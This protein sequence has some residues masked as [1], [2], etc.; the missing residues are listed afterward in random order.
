M[1]RSNR[2]I[3]GLLFLTF[4]LGLLGNSSLTT[5][6]PAAE[7]A[8]NKAE[9]RGTLRFRLFA[10]RPTLW[11]R[12]DSV[13]PDGSVA[14]SLHLPEGEA[15]NL[16]RTGFSR[17]MLSD[18]TE[19]YYLGLKG[20]PESGGMSLF[21][22]MS[23][24][25]IKIDDGRVLRVRITE[26]PVGG[27]ALATVGPG[28]LSQI[29]TG[30]RIVLIRPGGSSTAELQAVPDV[31]ALVDA[32]DEV[33]GMGR[34][35]AAH[36][37]R[38]KNNLKQIGIAIH[39]FHD[40]Y[41]QF[42]PAVV[43][44][45]DGK[46]WHSWRVL[47]LPYLEQ[48]VLYDRYRF[49]EPWDSPH[50]K[51]LLETVPPVFQDP[52]Y[53]K[54]EG[55]YTHYAA[56][57]GPGT[58]FPPEGHTVREFP[59]ERAW[60]G[61][62]APSGGMRFALIRDGSSNTVLAGSVSPNRKIPWT[63]PEDVAFGDSFPGI[64]REGGFAAPYQTEN[65]RGGVFLFGDG[66]VKAIRQDVDG[67][68]LRNLIT[69]AD[70]TPIGEVPQFAPTHPR[71]EQIPVV[72]IRRTETG[73]TAKLTLETLSPREKPATAPR[74]EPAT[75][76]G[77][78]YVEGTVTLHGEPLSNALV[79]FQ[80]EH[81]RPSYGRTDLEGWYELV[82]TAGNKGAKIGKHRVSISTKAEGDP[83]ADPP[84]PS[85]PEK[86]PAKYNRNTELTADVGDGD[87]VI[88]FP[89][90]SG[91][92][93]DD[94]TNK[95]VALPV[96]VRRA[97]VVAP[98]APVPQAPAARVIA[99]RPSARP[100]A[101]TTR[102][103]RRGTAAARPVAPAVTLPV[104]PAAEAPAP[105]NRET[106]VAQIKKLGG[107]LLVKGY[108]ASWSPDG[109]KIVFGGWSPGTRLE[110]GEGLGV[111]DLQSGKTTKLVA[112]GKD[113]AWS[114]GDGKWIAYVAGGYGAAEEVWVVEASGGEPRKLADG[115]YPSWLPDGKTVVF[116]SRKQ[117]KLMAV[118]ID[119]E[120]A[121]PKEL[122]NFSSWYPAVSADG[123]RVA[124]RSGS[125]QGRSSL[126]V[127]DLESGQV[128]KILPTPVGGRGFLG[129]WSP[130]GKRV[131]FG[132]FGA[133]DVAG[134]WTVN[135][136]NGQVVRISAGPC[137][138][139]AWSPDGSKIA[140]DLRAGESN[141]IWMVDT[142]A[143]DKLEPVD[144]KTIEKLVDRYAVPDGGPEVVLKYIQDLR[145][146]RPKTREQYDEH[147]AKSPAALA[148]AAK[149]I[150]KLEKDEWSEAYQTALLV[151]L[152]D[153]VR[154]IREDDLQRRRETLRHVETFLKAK[155]EKGLTSADARLAYSTARALEYADNPA[156][157][158]KAYERLAEYVAKVDDDRLADMAKA[159]EGAARRLSLPGNPMKLEGTMMDGAKFDWAAYRGKVV[160]VDFWATWCGPC[161]AELPNV[162]KNY[163]R[164]HD[165]GFDVI[166]VSLDR[167]REALEK[168]LADEQLPWITLH[169]KEA[170]GR[171]P[172]AAHYGIMAIPTVLLIDRE[173]NVASLRAR[174]AELDRLLGELIGPPYDP[175]GKLTYLDLQPQANQKLAEN[176][177]S[178]AAGG[179][180]LAELPAGEQ[181]FA[182]VK[183]RIGEG[184]IQLASR[185]LPDRPEKVDGIGVDQKLGR[186]YILHATGWGSAQD[187]VPDGTQIGEYRV[188]YEDGGEEA[189]PIVYG[190]DVRDW[191][192]S[193]G[194][195]SVTRGVLAWEGQNEAI[196][197]SAPDGSRSLRLYLL[198]WENP[199]PE[200]KI[201][202]IDY[203]STNETDAA[204]FCVAITA[205]AP[206]GSTEA[207]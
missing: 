73:A 63:K 101:I 169:E 147:R 174:G 134:L 49:N 172:I 140:F 7:P 86:V 85:F 62:S 180:N 190:Q 51:Q 44:G 8:S 65:A 24:S 186:L 64:G 136:E 93:I 98:A 109:G 102:S 175:K 165:R 75:E 2:A 31:V 187:A 198:A 42:P 104:A 58:A 121:E 135:V 41:K 50:N 77:L 45:P 144:R 88:D 204:P 91:S 133:H 124:Y 143:L 108:K 202:A 96:A 103:F 106:T 38:S 99:P 139:P 131:G 6:A 200:K 22:E 126:I 145:A 39:N 195:R 14:L 111:Y 148:A 170:E 127:A 70:G 163:R 194:S 150:L 26:I 76:A 177:H 9:D 137:T 146:F 116:H 83:D 48:I 176:M 32:R 112:S 81:A 61:R 117:R 119:A 80:P 79:T 5:E 19:G 12:V 107:K 196:K 185:R 34:A 207:L 28:A 15:A 56:I 168:F 47:L 113:P 74:D 40:T 16:A 66:T 54:A 35:E 154:T 29:K 162:R 160:L 167:D 201:T 23:R 125:H 182:G 10:F 37:T 18:L 123:R 164:Y 193:D 183:L 17:D 43:Y 173:G 21:F 132:G 100:A 105:P 129:G 171:S 27:K 20:L 122:I 156:L 72:E 90:K 1:F 11:F 92:E 206:D 82:F 4:G 197:A 114:P 181:T 52:I 87:N 67:Q 57:V 192:N 184:L 78:G 69:I 157:A 33:P 203:G 161:R 149:T 36:L 59:S 142:D 13:A 120:E 95:A 53:G 189:I 30:D 205:E 89:L 55:P 191:W 179:N 153:R 130:D 158:V 71:R 151:L 68:L 97:R 128:T 152:E 155:L 159:M 178:H 110:T 118:A 25:P 188:H 3:V 84:I 138:M 46:P 199:H 94:S 166:G 141:E 60:A 115:G